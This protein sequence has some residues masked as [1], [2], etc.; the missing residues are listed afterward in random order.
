MIRSLGKRI[1]KIESNPSTQPDD[2]AIIEDQM[3]K[4]SLSLNS[5]KKQKAIINTLRFET[6][7]DRYSSVS[8][9]H[10]QTFGWVFGPSNNQV[11]A[12]DAGRV[13]KWL[14]DEDDIFWISGKPGSGKSTFM[15]FITEQIHTRNALISWSH[16]KPIIFASHFFWSA[17]TPMQRSRQGLLRTLLYEIFRKVPGLIEASCTRRWSMTLDRLDHE[18]WNTKELQEVLTR[19]GDDQNLPVKF[20]FFVDGLDEFEGDYVDFCQ[21]LKDLSRSSHVKL[22]VSSRPRNVFEDYFGCNTLNKMYMHDVT[23]GDIQRYVQDRLERHP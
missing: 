12:K 10:E 9:P 19:I 6:L 20:C 22:C 4:L 16:P 21:G 3:S 8:E 7:Y 18:V 23:R 13:R 2:I 17:G 14:Y 5:I 11:V 1:T 15:K